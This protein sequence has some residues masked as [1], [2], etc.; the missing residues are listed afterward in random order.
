MDALLKH[1][2]MSAFRRG[3]KT[4]QRWF[5]A[6]LIPN[7][8]RTK[9]GAKRG[10]QYRIKTPA[11]TQRQHVERWMQLARSYRTGHGGWFVFRPHEQR[12]PPA[13]V[14]WALKAGTNIENTLTRQAEAKRRSFVRDE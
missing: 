6:G 8:Y 2:L 10:G 11:G 14:A 13:F 12:L 3:P 7:T 9:G 5:K 1:F 4:L